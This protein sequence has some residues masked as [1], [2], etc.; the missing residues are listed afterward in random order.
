MALTTVVGP[1][2]TEG[3]AV[4]TAQYL[5]NQYSVYSRSIKNADGLETESREWFVE[6]DDS[7]VTNLFGYPINAFLAKQYK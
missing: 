6:R 4:E 5:G 3:E 1:L 7:I 2:K